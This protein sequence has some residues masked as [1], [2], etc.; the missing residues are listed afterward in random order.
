[1]PTL[2]GRPREG[3]HNQ[4]RDD[5]VEKIKTSDAKLE[6]LGY[7]DWDLMAPADFRYYR[8]RIAEF[9]SQSQLV[10]REALLEHSH[11]KVF[12]EE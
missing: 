1:M 4:Y 10:G 6:F 11:A 9:N 3:D 12:V 7:F 5:P 8:V 2:I